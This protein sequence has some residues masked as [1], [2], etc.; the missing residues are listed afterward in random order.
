MAEPVD[1]GIHGLSAAEVI[2]RGGFGIVYRATQLAVGRAVAVK[3]LPTVGRGDAARRR[4]EREGTAMAAVSS[5]P[6]I[7]ALHDTGMSNHGGPYI[8]M[9]YVPGGTY[10]E[11][12]PLPWQ[13]GVDVGVKLAGALETAHR[14]GIIHRD[15]KPENILRSPYGEP[16]LTDFGI[17]KVAES[18]ETPS[19]SLTASLLHAAPET[20]SGSRPS[21][22]SDVYALASTL[23]TFI[24]GRPPFA[25]SASEESLAPL[26]TRI[27]TAP[28]PDFG[29][30]AV[31][32]EVFA[33]LSRAM[34][35][36]PADRPQSPAEFGRALAAAQREVGLTPTAIRI[37][38]V[39]PEPTPAPG[40]PRRTRQV[41]RRAPPPPLPPSTA[42]PSPSPSGRW[43][44]IVA[45]AAAIAVAGGVVA[46][47]VATRG[48]DGVETAAARHS[49]PPQTSSTPSASTTPPRTTVTPTA[50]QRLRAT[51]PRAAGLHACHE[52][53]GG[54]GLLA[55]VVC[56]TRDGGPAV[57]ARVYWYRAGSFS[58]VFGRTVPATVHQADGRCPYVR[59]RSHYLDSNKHDQGQLACWV[60]T[61]RRPYVVWT[62]QKGRLLAI[63]EG[64]RGK[65]VQNIWRGWNQLVLRVPA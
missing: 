32:D 64:A 5:H 44:A 54:T 47:V 63:L 25:S 11:R 30:L 28:V 37:E 7:V 3:M 45:A 8:V 20:L 51:L 46:A 6:H 52:G 17:A 15:V 35:K 61:D 62:L 41:Q 4:F 2:G 19:G 16:L 53:P 26:L 29:S 33:V 24:A 27:S 50:Y 10:A 9:E 55:S 12:L 39:D 22:A 48:G 60:A 59:D 40:A 1:L 57:Q 38:G 43:K 13:Q 65:S 42:D 58:G 31:P 21:A 49:T 23:Y 18:S 36:D 14:A 34:A 56:D